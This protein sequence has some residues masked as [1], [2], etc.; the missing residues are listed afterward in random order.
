MPSK[1]KNLVITGLPQHHL[2]SFIDWAEALELTRDQL[3]VALMV[4]S[5][6]IEGGLDAFLPDRKAHSEWQ[7]LL[8][9]GLFLV[10]KR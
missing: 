2:Q 4:N 6:F 8:F 3:L 7:Q 1:A 5:G 9:N 10:N